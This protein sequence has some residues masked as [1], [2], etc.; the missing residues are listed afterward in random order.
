MRWVG[1]VA[2]VGER[3]GVYRVL[4]G[5]PEGKRPLGRPRHRWEDNI[6]M[7]LQEVGC[8]SSW[9]GIRTGGGHLWMRYWTFGFHK[10]RRISWLTEKRLASQEGLASV[11]TSKCLYW[12]LKKLSESHSL[13]YCSVLHHWKY[14]EQNTLFLGRI[15]QLPVVFLL[16]VSVSV[17]D[18]H[19]AAAVWRPKC[20]ALLSGCCCPLV[21]A[22][23]S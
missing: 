2:C 8:R 3:R 9:L 16:R 14:N 13:I 19:V 17:G 22:E 4:V 18:Y 5:K 11:C 6:R 23:C 1:H 20:I 7:D 21:V 10:M 15:L 12:E